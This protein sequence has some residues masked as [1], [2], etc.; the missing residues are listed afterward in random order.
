MVNMMAAVM[1]SAPESASNIMRVPRLDRKAI[2]LPIKPV[3]L[4]IK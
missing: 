4:L 2:I 3:F 1:S